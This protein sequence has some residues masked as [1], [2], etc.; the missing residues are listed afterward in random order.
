MRKKVTINIILFTIMGFSTLA[1]IGFVI[2][3]K[4]HRNIKDGAALEIRAVDLYRTIARD[5]TKTK[6]NFLNKIVAVTGEVSQIQKNRDGGQVI[7]LQT[8]VPNASINCTMEE[9][10]MEIKAGDT[11]VIKGLC[12]GYIGANEDIGLPGDVFLIRCYTTF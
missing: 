7:L 10:A 9:N 5:N 12:I 4:P 1:F 6:S 11:I 3:N 2:W 8:N